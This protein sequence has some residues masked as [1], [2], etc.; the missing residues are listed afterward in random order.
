MA[1]N[2]QPIYV[3]A[4][5][6]E[7]ALDNID[8]TTNNISNSSTPGFKKLLMREFSQKIPENLGKTS[9]LFVFPRF[10][11]SPVIVNQGA[12]IKTDNMFDV[13]IQGKGFFAVQTENGVVYTRN[14]HFFRNAEGYLVDANGNYILD[15]NNQK[16]RLTADKVIFS[17]DGAVIQNNQVVAKLQ[18]RN[19]QN[20]IPLGNG[21]YQGQNEIQPQYTLNQGFLESSNSNAIEEMISLINNHRRFDIY[22]N[23]IKSLDTLEGK[24]N[25]I[26]RV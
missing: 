4:T 20:I 19:F 3:L 16:I 12:L 11:D 18:I 24:V 23:L 2:F 1:I 7:R 9:E 17:A 22:M 10:Q 8:I 15:T 14:G 25:E 26:G 6:G 21:Y 5:G 13:A